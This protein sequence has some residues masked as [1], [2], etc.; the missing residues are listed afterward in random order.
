MDH[1]ATAKPPHLANGPWPDPPANP[2]PPRPPVAA[3]KPMRTRKKLRPKLNKADRMRMAPK[4]HINVARPQMQGFIH[5][6]Q[7]ATEAAAGIAG[8]PCQRPPNHL[9]PDS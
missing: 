4:R 6:P 2:G 1:D 5:N 8:D 9:G 3:K 7:A